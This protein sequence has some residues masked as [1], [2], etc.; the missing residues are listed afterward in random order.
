MSD[1]RF[2]KNVCATLGTIYDVFEGRSDKFKLELF[3]QQK[4]FILNLKYV[5]FVGHFSFKKL[6]E[7][8]IPAIHHGYSSLA[9]KKFDKF[10]YVE[11]KVDKLT[12]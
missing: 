4:H 9:G 3:E 8:V 10:D 11:S 2:T 7:L 6:D 5:P 12:E 1:V